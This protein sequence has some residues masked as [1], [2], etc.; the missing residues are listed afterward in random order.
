MSLNFL[1]FGLNIKNTNTKKTNLDEEKLQL[2]N[3]NLIFPDCSKLKNQISTILKKIK[4]VQKEQISEKLKS[5]KLQILREKL[6]NL[7]E[8]L[9][10]KLNLNSPQINEIEPLCSFEEMRK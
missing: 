3:E 1:K 8:A 2:E 10:E 5:K 9:N 7:K 6:T 4:L